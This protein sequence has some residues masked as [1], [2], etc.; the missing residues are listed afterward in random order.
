MKKYIWCQW[1]PMNQRLFV[2]YSR[3]PTAQKSDDMQLKSPRPEDVQVKPVLTCYQ[4]GQSLVPFE[5][6]VRKY[7]PIFCLWHFIDS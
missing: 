7:L 2:L 3:K 5:A 4:F 1:D 6:V